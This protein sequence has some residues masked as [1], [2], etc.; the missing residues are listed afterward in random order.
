M[1]MIDRS[2]HLP[3]S[4]RK[5]PAGGMIDGY[6]NGEV[7]LR[8]ATRV[9]W[10]E[11]KTLLSHVEWRRMASLHGGNVACSGERLL[12]QGR[13]HDMGAWAAEGA[14]AESWSWSWRSAWSAEHS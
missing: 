6:T 4:G 13:D 12:Q 1:G 14:T 7:Y 2:A 9:H 5:G 10:E 3:A 8:Q 11:G